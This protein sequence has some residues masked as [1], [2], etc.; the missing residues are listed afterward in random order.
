MSVVG[1][2]CW[3][4]THCHLDDAA[5]A[6]D[7]D[8][9][10]QR[11]VAAG[12][13]RMI[14]VGTSAASSL[15][16]VEW[17]ARYPAVHAAVGIQ[18]NAVAEA[19][20]DDWDRIAELAT[21]PRVVAI[22]ETGLDR[23][24]DFTPFEL[25]CD[26]FDRHLRLAQSLGLPVVIHCR[27]AWDEMLAALRRAAQRG[28]LRGVM[29]AFSGDA[30]QASECVALG[31]HVSL[32]GN[33]TYTNRKFAALIEAAAAVPL[34]RLV[35]ETDSPYLVPQPLRGRLRRNEPAHLLYTAEQVAALRGL[36]LGELAEATTANARRL[37]VL[38]GDDTMG[39][40]VAIG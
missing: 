39:P 15:A 10:I 22:G 32:A 38:P 33:V 9:V 8:V 21:R 14:T 11:A 19:A 25:Q 29:H 23:H 36:S 1:N 37:F 34:D 20:P 35:L 26:V 7:V 28:P 27:E 40:A 5:L 2:R 6:G 31:L 18:P 13:A 30:A 16:A 3:I 12:V 24:W 17:A 4:D